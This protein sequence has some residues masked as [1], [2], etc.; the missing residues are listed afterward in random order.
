MGVDT[1][2]MWKIVL[3]FICLIALGVTAPGYPSAYPTLTGIY[4]F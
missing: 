4:N 3:F 1:Q 2:A